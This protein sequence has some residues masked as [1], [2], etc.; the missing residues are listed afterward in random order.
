MFGTFMST[1]RTRRAQAFKPVGV[2]PA[3]FA[4]AL[5]SS[6]SGQDAVNR[7]WTQCS[8]K[9]VSISRDVDGA[10][11]VDGVNVQRPMQTEKGFSREVRAWS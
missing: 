9:R 4:G 6:A 2:A 8:A 5:S 1:D 7:A 11:H 10:K 3:G